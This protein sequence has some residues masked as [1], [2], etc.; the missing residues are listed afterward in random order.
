MKL[1]VTGNDHMARI[2]F[3]SIIAQIESWRVFVEAKFMKPRVPMFFE[4]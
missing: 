3:G 1:A 4:W 2:L